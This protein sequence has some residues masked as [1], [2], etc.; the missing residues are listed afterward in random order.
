MYISRIQV[1]EGFLDGLDIQLVPGLNVIIGARGTGKTSLIELVRFCM[2]VTGHS[3]ESSKKSLDHA[4]SVLGSGQ[5]TVTLID[6]TREITITRTA[7]DRAPRSSGLFVPPIVF[8]QTEIETVGLQP[9]G[10]LALL[11]AFAGDRRRSDI[12]ESKAVSEIQSLTTEVETIRR[13]LDE[14][15]QQLAQLPIIDQQISL[16]APSEKQIAALSSTAAGKKQRLD[17]LSAL[18]AAK[19]VASSTI[20]RFSTNVGRWKT[21]LQS[22]LNSAPGQDVWPPNGGENLL[23]SA[24]GHLHTA[25]KHIGSALDELLLAEREGAKFAT[26]L[27]EEKVK[28]EDEARQLRKEIETLKTGAGTVARQGQQLREQK[29]Q[30]ESL[31]QVADERNR[32]LA[33]VIAQRSVALDTLDKLRDARFKLRSD[34]ASKL[35]VTLGPKIKITVGTAGQFDAYTSAIADVLRGSGLRYG[36]LAPTLAKSVSPRE[37]L[38]ATDSNDFAL[39]I[40]ATGISKDRIIRIL[41]HLKTADLGTLATV[42]VDDVVNFQL[43]DGLEYKDISELSTGQRCTVVLPLVLRHTG[44]LLIVDQ[45]EDHIDNAFIADTLIRSILAREPNGQLIFSTHNAN[46]PVLGN[47]DRV[48]QLGSDGRRGFALVSAEL[49][50]APAV[51]AITTVMEGGIEAFGRRATFYG[52]HKP[53]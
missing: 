19:A 42:P 39:L 32:K 24:H 38:D 23:K 30:L 9:K 48:I 51:N 31:R 22:V 41:S 20:D 12:E 15:T 1:E 21:S 17:Q 2:D 8:S 35:N 16:L 53:K 46:I 36:D 49:N 45:P 4:L 27:G 34:T 50:A 28:I 52:R 37:L 5:I 13:E 44:R 11:D 6:G 7:S 33:A 3:A 47:A 43:L 40:D 29:A 10:R 26:A 14:L 18:I 25:I